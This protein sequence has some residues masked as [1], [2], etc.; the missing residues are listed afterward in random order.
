MFQVSTKSRYGIRALVEL[1]VHSDGSPMSLK[2][3]SSGQDISKKYL[4]NI[5]RMLHKNGIVRSVRG[6]KGGY[7]LGCQP[8]E[9]TVLAI[10]DAIDGPVQLMDCINDSS[11][12]GKTR[13]CFTREMWVELEEHIKEFLAGKTLKDLIE[14]YQQADGEFRGMY[15]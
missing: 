12:C 14:N 2:E 11:V 13:D 1:A 8:A 10:M 7:L 3:L 6:A 4:E 5:F 15:I 9:L